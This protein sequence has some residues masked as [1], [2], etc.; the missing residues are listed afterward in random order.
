MGCRSNTRGSCMGARLISDDDGVSGN[1]RCTARSSGL[2]PGPGRRRREFVGE[3][4]EVVTAA[5]LQIEV[6]F[7]VRS[8]A[9]PRRPSRTPGS[10]DL[11]FRRI[12]RMPAS[13]RRQGGAI[14]RSLAGC[15]HLREPACPCRR[16]SQPDRPRSEVAVQD[17]RTEHGSMT[18]REIRGAVPAR[19]I[20]Q[21]TPFRL[22]RC[23]LR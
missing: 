5:W 6:T 23:W 17:R 7:T 3:G 4:V 9:D 22:G 12:P 16:G 10:Y 2:R 19:G 20:A 11:R 1:A 13:A 8:S 14:A 15:W 18:Q 21:Q